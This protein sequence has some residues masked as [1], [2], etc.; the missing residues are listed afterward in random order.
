MPHP[1]AQFISSFNAA[2]YRACVE[3]L[4]ELWFEERDDFHKGLIRLCVALHQLR[5]GLLT[6]PYFLL[7]TAAELLRP[8]APVYRGIDIAALLEFIDR[9]LALFP[10]DQSAEERVPV[11]RIPVFQLEVKEGAW[12]SQD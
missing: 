1:F 7:S 6:S 11:E 9:C 2:D 12:P 10:K 5:L 4:E 3:P 8:Y